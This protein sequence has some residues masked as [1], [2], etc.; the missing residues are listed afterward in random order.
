MYQAGRP[1]RRNAN[2]QMKLHTYGLMRDS[3]RLQQDMEYVRTIW[4][5]RDFRH[6]KEA[7]REVQHMQKALTKMNIPVSQRDQRYQRTQ[8]SGDHHRRSRGRA[9][10]LP[11]GG[12]G[13]LPG[14]GKPAKRWRAAW[15]ETGRAE[16]VRSNCNRPSIVTISPTDA[17][18]Q[19]C[20]EKLAL[21]P[22]EP[23]DSNTGYPCCPVRRRTGERVGRREKR[24]GSH[25]TTNHADGRHEGRTPT[26]LRE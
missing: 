16:D 3:F 22:G 25:G 8:R 23:A 18:T 1:T 7:G 20:D 13:R 17:K 26:D 6:V 14:Q 2:G 21:L 24:R 5:V 12:F 4:R 19:E 15:R 10:P 9:G 11:T